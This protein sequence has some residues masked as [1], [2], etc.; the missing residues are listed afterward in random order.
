M[1]REHRT[2]RHASLV[3]PSPSGREQGEQL[4]S[5]ALGCATLTQGERELASARSAGFTL[6]EVLVAF[7]IAALALGVLF[8]GGIGGLTTANAA[9]RYDEALSRAQS[10]LALASVGPD[11]QAQD[12]QGE[13]GNGYHWHLR[14]Q[15]LAQAAGPDPSKPAPALYGIAIGM[16]WRDGPHPRSL[17]LQT[18]RL[19]TAPPPPP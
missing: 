17:A 12:R 16:D 13:E 8:Q 4:G 5:P 11:F 9:A 2:G 15:L 10:H 14:I 19:G 6:L 18:E 1:G 7:V 3:K